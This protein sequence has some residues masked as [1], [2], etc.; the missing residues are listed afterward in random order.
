MMKLFPLQ[1][2]IY[3]HL[4]AAILLTLDWDRGLKPL[5]PD[6]PGDFLLL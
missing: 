3:N 4:T 6:H 2:L 5:R 1:T